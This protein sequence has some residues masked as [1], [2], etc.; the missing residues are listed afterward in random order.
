MSSPTPNNMFT[1]TYRRFIEKQDEEAVGASLYEAELEHEALEQ[2][3]KQI[4]DQHE[5]RRS[6]RDQHEPRNSRPR[7]LSGSLGRWAHAGY[8]GAVVGHVLETM[9]GRYM[10]GEF[11][12]AANFAI[13]TYNKAIKQKLDEVME[14]QWKLPY[15]RELN[16]RTFTK[17]NPVCPLRT[18][19]GSPLILPFAPTM[20]ENAHVLFE[21]EEVQKEVVIPAGVKV[22][23]LKPTHPKIAGFA[24]PNVFS[25]NM[26]PDASIVFLTEEF[27]EGKRSD[28]NAKVEN[29]MRATADPLPFAPGEWQG[30]P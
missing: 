12:E 10:K 28:D 11:G 13:E 3:L 23:V 27:H 26:S 9:Y 15:K 20:Q 18:K 8:P 21:C 1:D 5:Q 30:D 14:R 25:P 6:R 4:S 17:Y 24:Y 22:L 16:A 7:V 2:R 29:A 19:E